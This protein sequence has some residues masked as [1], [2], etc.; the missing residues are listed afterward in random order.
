[1]ISPL[2][3]TVSA[4]Q[5]YKSRMEA[6]SNNIANI[7]T[8]EFKKSQAVL[9]EGANGDVQV[10]VTLSDTAGQPY[11]AFEDNQRHEKQTSNVEL[12]KELPQM[13]ATQHAYNANM[14]VIQTQDEILGST[15]NIVG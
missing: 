12:T 7:T 9:K 14:K 1:M 4:L 10:H 15:L 11:Q 13:M 6:T 5:A 3:S 2:S 8:A